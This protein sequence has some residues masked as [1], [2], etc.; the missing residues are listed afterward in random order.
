M[1]N[2]LSLS[3]SVSPSRG[4][5]GVQSEG[6]GAGRGGQHHH[7]HQ[8][9]GGGPQTHSHALQDH[10]D[11]APPVGGPRGE[12]QGTW[13]RVWDNFPSKK[14]VE[15]FTLGWKLENL[16]VFYTPL[17]TTFFFLL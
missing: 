2:I 16:H 8:H 3:L 5:R 10:D 9:R 11:G 6:G 1:T 7:L 15:I 14:N 12:N 17:W 13:G 4:G